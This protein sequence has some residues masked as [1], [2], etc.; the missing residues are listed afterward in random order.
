MEIGTSLLAR[1]RNEQGNV[2]DRCIHQSGGMTDLATL[3]KVTMI[4]CDNHITMMQ[5]TSSREIGHDPTKFRIHLGDRFV[6]FTMIFLHKLLRKII[7]C[8]W[9]MRLGKPF[10]II[11]ENSNKILVHTIG[12]MRRPK[13]KVT[14][15]WR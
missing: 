1:R 12:P 4:G 8:Q 15:T 6:I 13:V 5:N 14:E 11:L 10:Q 7:P 2:R 3:E 9:V